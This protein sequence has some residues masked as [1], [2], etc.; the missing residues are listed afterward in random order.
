MDIQM[1]VMDGYEATKQIRLNKK[2]ANLPIIALTA[3]AMVEVRK[4]ITA[5]GMNNMV[6]K[7]FEPKQLFTAV[8]KSLYS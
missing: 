1:P 2:Y 7:P 8:L 3:S 4:K 5:A 6:T